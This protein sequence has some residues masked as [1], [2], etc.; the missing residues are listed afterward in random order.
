MK[1]GTPMFWMQYKL[2]IHEHWTKS[3]FFSNIKKKDLTCLVYFKHSH[4]R[5]FD[6]CY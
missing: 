6:T 3:I 4:E 1:M 5:D 2:I